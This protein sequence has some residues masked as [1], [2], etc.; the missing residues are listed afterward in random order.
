[1]NKAYNKYLLLSVIG[2]ISVYNLKLKQNSSLVLSLVICGAFEGFI[3]TQKCSSV[4]LRANT[5]NSVLALNCD[6]DWLKIFELVTEKQ[7]GET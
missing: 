1:M 6:W 5:A 2:N 3:L 7:T 4:M